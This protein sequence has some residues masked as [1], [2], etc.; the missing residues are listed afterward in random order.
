MY[1]LFCLSGALCYFSHPYT[2]SALANA[3]C[4]GW[5][6]HTVCRCG[7]LL[8]THISTHCLVLL[9]LNA[10]VLGCLLL[11]CHFHRARGRA[12]G[13]SVR[14]DGLPIF[15]AVRCWLAWSQRV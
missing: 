1:W 2:L 5:C 9:V 10:S 13:R 12:Y 11:V 4:Y 8:L 15:M 14:S 6:L 7:L 3:F